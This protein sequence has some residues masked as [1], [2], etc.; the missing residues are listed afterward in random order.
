[1]D[2]IIRVFIGA[3]SDVDQEREI[4]KK[5]INTMNK[6][7]RGTG[8][9]KFNLIELKK[10][11]MPDI[12]SGLEAQEIIDESIGDYDLF[13]GILWK[14]FGTPTKTHESGTQQEFEN[15]LKSDAK[16]MFY[17]SNLPLTPDEVVPEQFEKIINFK[18]KIKDKGLYFEYSSL[19]EFEE[20]IENN[21][22][23]LAIEK[24]NPQTQ[25]TKKFKEED[26]EKSMF[27]LI[28][29]T[30][31]NFKEVENDAEE[32]TEL[33]ESLNDDFENITPPNENNL[34]SYKIYSNSVADLL[35]D[36]SIKFKH[37]KNDLITH[38]SN[39]IEDLIESLELFGEYM[40]ENTRIEL[41]KGIETHIEV[42]NDFTTQMHEVIEMYDE[43]PPVTNKLT[44]AKSKFIKNIKELLKDLKNL[45]SMLYKSLIELNDSSK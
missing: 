33:F 24:N 14:R 32:L 45:R 12:G 10:D 41:R 20:L 16:V 31:N 22:R 34:Q 5:V 19:E 4:I 9:S 38:Y 3:P 44:R 2:N 13:I 7:Y 23:I 40:D 36:L 35:N 26:E 37:G 27:D 43:I 11:V 25:T 28:E 18:N 39:G 15:A 30:L 42:L 1:M 29:S 8:F 6:F 17:F 21:L